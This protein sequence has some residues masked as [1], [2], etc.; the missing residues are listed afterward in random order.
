MLLFIVVAVACL[1]LGV[2]AVIVMRNYVP[3]LKGTSSTDNTS[4]ALARCEEVIKASL[5]GPDQASFRS[6]KVTALGSD[7]YQ[8]TGTID[9]PN[10]TGVIVRGSYNCIFNFSTK[11]F[12]LLSL[13]GDDIWKPLKK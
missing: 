4:K 2:V 3:D 9:A 6:Q 12:D 1:A 13:E 10:V 7:R 5:R 11:S 8:V